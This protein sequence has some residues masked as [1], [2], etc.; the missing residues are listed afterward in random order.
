MEV[1]VY[2]SKRRVTLKDGT[3]K[4]YTTRRKYTPKGVKEAKKSDIID[5]LKRI[6]D[7]QSLIE[8]KEFILKYD[9]EKRQLAENPSDN[10]GD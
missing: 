10:G 9:R 8:I 2:E 5:I 7:R 6:D 1:K 3:V 4:E